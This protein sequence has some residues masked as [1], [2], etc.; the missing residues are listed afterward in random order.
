MPPLRIHLQ[1]KSHFQDLILFQ[2]SVRYS[3]Q[4][5]N[6]LV[7]PVDRV[8]NSPLC[9]PHWHLITV[10]LAQ[11]M[12]PC[13]GQRYFCT[14]ALLRLLSFHPYSDNVCPVQGYSS[15]VELIVNPSVLISWQNIPQLDITIEHCVYS[16][17][18]NCS[19]DILTYGKILNQI[20]NDLYKC[21]A[22][23]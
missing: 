4:E 20:F 13:I 8:L 14:H 5:R 7:P 10:Q 22:F 9:T 12:G 16:C 21:I 23:P 19:D 3:D 6:Q 1:H 2:R 17:L 18:I 15:S 11:D